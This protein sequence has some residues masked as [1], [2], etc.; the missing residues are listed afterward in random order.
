MNASHTHN[1]H[2]FIKCKKL[3]RFMGAFKDLC[4]DYDLA[5]VLENF[6]RNYEFYIFIAVKYLYA[7]SQ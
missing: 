3:E 7:N 4:V 1:I 5:M 2:K 6:C